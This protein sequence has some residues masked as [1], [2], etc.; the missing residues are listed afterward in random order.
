MLKYP[1]IS[2]LVYLFLELFL[3]IEFGSYFGIFFVFLEFI[4]SAV[5][6]FVI[7]TNFK[8]SFAQSLRELSA[9]QIDK[10]EFVSSNLFSVIGAVLLIIP[11]IFTDI[12]GIL[13]QFSIFS[14]PTFGYVSKYVKREKKFKRENFEEGE[15]IDVEIVKSSSDK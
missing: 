10:K 6:G 5:L 3:I 12:L 13:M 9:M 11:G 4:V 15:V 1:F 7:L 14:I 8:Y 2:F